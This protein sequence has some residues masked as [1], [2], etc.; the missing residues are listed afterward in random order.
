[1][2]EK[3]IKL[4]IGLGASNRYDALCEIEKSVS[5]SSMWCFARDFN[6][7]DEE[8]SCEEFACEFMTA[9]NNEVYYK[10]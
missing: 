8:R 4:M 2:L 9:F 1:M 10:Y 5:L 6:L 3:A 7:L